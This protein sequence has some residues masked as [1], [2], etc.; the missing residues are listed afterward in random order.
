MVAPISHALV[1]PDHNFL[2]WYRAAE[3]YSLRFPRVEVVRGPTGNDL[4]R[5]RD[6]TA[7]ETPN[8]WLNND[9]AYHI[10]RIYPSVVL[11]DVVAAATPDVL[12]T[13]LTQRINL[14]D[15]YGENIDGGRHIDERLTIGFP[16]DHFPARIVRGFDE[17]VDGGRRHE[18]IDVA[19]EPGKNVVSA[20]TGTITNVVTT[21]N[22]VGYGRYVQVQHV[23][24]SRTYNLIYTNLD[25]IAVSR[26]QIVEKDDVLG[27]SKG[28]T[29]KLVMQAPGRGMHGYFL[30]DVINPI[31]LLYWDGMRL[32]TTADGVRIRSRGGVNYPALGQVYI[33]DS[34]EPLE[35]HGRTLLKV[36]VTDKW[37]RVRTPTGIEGFGAAWLLTASAIEIPEGLNM[38]GMNLDIAMT[39][40]RPSPERMRGIGWTRFTYD[41][42]RNTG[43]TDFDAAENLYRPYIERYANA[44]QQPIV[45]LNHETYGEGKFDWSQMTSE[46]WAALR[47]D[48]S[49]ACRDIARR[50]AGDSIIGA[51]QIWNEQD[52]P[53]GHGVAAVPMPVNEYAKL[54]TDAIRAIRS[55]DPNV[56]ILTG[57]HISGVPNGVN[58]ANAT[59][60][61]MPSNVRPDG[62]A[63]HAYGL[64]SPDSDAKFRPFGTIGRAV[65]S[66]A[67]VID[68]PVWITEWGL[69]EVPDPPA[70]VADFATKFIAN[71][72]R[73]YLDRV[74]AAV[75]F[76][77]ADGMHT[78]Y[79]IVDANGNPKQPL[80]D[81]YLNA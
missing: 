56:K 75:W 18:G 7:V 32:R 72:K 46:S 5:F 16:S 28:H 76:A 50:Y 68:A 9:A 55:V 29:F 20:T 48:F 45:I 27:T 11:I 26:G 2:D 21:P 81:A 15:R 54:L 67:K 78:S 41:V 47:N 38:T 25:D 63:F 40:G 52:T 65:I 8:V 71:L 14:E 4:N 57:G 10:R 59:I 36:G 12:K 64:G 30:P 34:L 24:R 13:K 23:F 66:Y 3:E 62:V 39:Q 58:Y 77:W 35:T 42:S 43:S 31:P 70:A 61:A 19:T 79:G 22:I 73:Y 6:V 51:Y 80:Y 53:P 17:L 33:N 44:G 69:P 37:L 60:A 1:L 74:A 49:N